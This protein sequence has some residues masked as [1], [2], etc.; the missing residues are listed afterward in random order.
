MAEVKA[1]DAEETTKDVD[2]Q[3][4]SD[5]EEDEPTTAKEG[6]VQPTPQVAVQD[7]DKDTTEA[8]DKVIPGSFAEPA[9]EYDE[10]EDG[11][12][13]FGDDFDDFE[14][15]GDD[16]DFDD[17]EDGFQQAEAEAPPAPAAAPVMPPSTL[18]FVSQPV[19]S[20]T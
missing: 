5:A 20:V 13:D 18:P 4:S 14:E 8:D 3:A 17:F 15:G 2:T 19:S 12:E 6:D 10:D 1:E 7:M 11:D 16:A 9:D